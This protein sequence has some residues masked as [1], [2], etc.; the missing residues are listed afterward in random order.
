MPLRICPKLSLSIILTFTKLIIGVKLKEALS[1]TGT[2]L[3]GDVAMLS[4]YPPAVLFISSSALNGA[5][6]DGSPI[7][8]FNIVAQSSS[9]LLHSR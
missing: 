5:E 7:V 4:P 1:P 6:Y 8:L 2:I 9:M 3:Y